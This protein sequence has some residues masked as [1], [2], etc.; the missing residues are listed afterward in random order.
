MKKRKSSPGVA[1]SSDW[2]DGP[3]VRVLAVSVHSHR[4][5]TKCNLVWGLGITFIG[6][7]LWVGL[8][9]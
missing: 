4:G 8:I 3:E 2:V 5:E 7:T 9:K 6:I 1:V